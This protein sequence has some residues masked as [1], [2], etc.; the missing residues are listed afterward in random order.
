MRACRPQ[1]ILSL[2]NS[3]IVALLVSSLLQTHLQAVLTP[4]PQD[5]DELAPMFITEL[6]RAESQVTGVGDGDLVTI[7][8]F[9]WSPPINSN[10]D[11]AYSAAMYNWD[12]NEFLDGVWLYQDGTIELLAAS[13]QEAPQLDTG[14]GSNLAG[15]LG[16]EFESLN[17]SDRVQTGDDPPKAVTSFVS[18]G[19]FIRRDDEIGEVVARQ[20]WT[21]WA[22][23]PDLLN[24]VM[25]P[26]VSYGLDFPLPDDSPFVYGRPDVFLN[27]A[28]HSSAYYLFPQQDVLELIVTLDNGSSSSL[29]EVGLSPGGSPSPLEFFSNV[30]FNSGSSAFYK[31]TFEEYDNED[32]T[33]PINSGLY[34]LSNSTGGI[35]VEEGQMAPGVDDMFFNSFFHLTTGGDNFAFTADLRPQFSLPVG[36][37]TTGLWVGDLEGGL[38]LVAAYKLQDPNLKIPISGGGSIT[39]TNFQQIYLSPG[40]TVFFVGQTLERGWGIWEETSAGLL[41]LINEND[42]TVDAQGQPTAS[43]YGHLGT[44]QLY[45]N[46]EDHI[47]FIDDTDSGTGL[48]AQDP[49][50]VLRR[51]IESNQPVI[52][53]EQEVFISGVGRGES[54]SGSGGDDGRPS[55]F[56]DN[57]DLA[58]TTGNQILR[59]SFETP[60]T[61]FVW[62]FRCDELNWHSDC[63]EFNWLE[64]TPA[65]LPADHIPGDPLG[66]GP[67]E[68][69]TIPDDNVT[70]DSAPV[71]LKSIFATGRLT[72]QQPLSIS[73]DSSIEDL[74]LASDLDISS[75]LTLTGLTNTISGGEI[76]G[77]GT[78]ILGDNGN[79]LHELTFDTSGTPFSLL[80]TVRTEA[81]A[82]WIHKN[83]ELQIFEDG[84]YLNINDGLLELQSGSIRRIGL[85]PPESPQFRLAS[86]LV[87]TGSGEFNIHAQMLTEELSSMSI[88]E[89]KLIINSSSIIQGDVTIDQDASLEMTSSF[90]LGGLGSQIMSG[91]GQMIISSETVKMQPGS[92]AGMN[93]MAPGKIQ[94]E[95][96]LSIINESNENPGFLTFEKDNLLEI[97]GD[98]FVIISSQQEYKGETHIKG[99]VLELRGTSF[100]NGSVFEVDASTKLNLAEGE[101]EVDDFML[102]SGEGSVEFLIDSLFTFKIPDNP[103][104]FDLNPAQL[105]LSLPG[106]EPAGFIHNGGTLNGQAKGQ[107]L[108]RG[109]YLFK[110]G[111]LEGIEI[112]NESVSAEQAARIEFAEGSVITSSL[113][114]SIL[115]NRP[116]N[117]IHQPNDLLFE[118]APTLLINNEGDYLIGGDILQ[119]SDGF[120]EP[121]M[122]FV[123]SPGTLLANEPGPVIINES[124]AFQNQ[125]QDFLTN[126]NVELGPGAN[127]TIENC[128]NIK[129]SPPGLSISADIE[130]N[131]GNWTVNQGATLTLFNK[132]VD[133][134]V[135]A[136]I[137]GGIS[138]GST[139]ELINDGRLL[140]KSGNLQPTGFPAT[141]HIYIADQSTL[142]LRNPDSQLASSVTLR[143]GSSMELFSGTTQVPIIDVYEA[144]SLVLNDATLIVSSRLYLSN[145]TLEGNGTINGEVVSNG[146]IQPGKSPG[147]IVINGDFTQEENAVL[148]MELGGLQ[149]AG[150][151]Y[152]Q[153]VV[154]GTA[155]LNGTLM[156]EEIS[157]FDWDFGTPVDLIQATS[158]SGSFDRVV[159]INSSRVIVETSI[160]EGILTAQSNLVEN[161]DEWK[162]VNFSATDQSNEAISGHHADPDG[163]DIENLL[164]YASDTNPLQFDAMPVTFDWVPNESND[165]WSVQV[166]FPWAKG[167]TDVEYKLQTSMDMDTWEDAQNIVTQKVDGELTDQVTIEAEVGGEPVYVRLIVRETAL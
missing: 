74:R 13:G 32:G 138:G 48:W 130:I 10:G 28:G 85:L 112:I 56:S 162:T 123:N 88:E 14:S 7:S 31:G 145:G 124:V 128:L 83:G 148:H 98:E 84:G 20:S 132:E 18:Y 150:T 2:N 143:T 114:P 119:K 166:G 159:L 57:G 127:L 45:I 60:V 140:F 50:G 9:D 115:L 102:V 46:A 126:G 164:E 91:T 15:Y 81:N 55:I 1:P 64:N 154:N 72:V 141:A 35:L 52:I 165:T 147:S 97:T 78:L 133:D 8:I 146:V 40:G 5:P 95:S 93:F 129:E 65:M 53:D 54:Q 106:S 66:R 44:V 135:T 96:P 34:W 157:G 67:F 116:Q 110:L 41:E 101:H 24:R 113:L 23:E 149:M 94:L 71:S 122:E 75:N 68:S 121:S 21:Y 92:L 58:V 109:N 158:Y 103:D 38:R 27:K 117:E 19:N 120:I 49:T 17:L 47:A 62:E 163:D 144:S 61:E 51:I 104:P 139:V 6:A 22:T 87:K 30:H 59:I 86:A 107:V 99:G 77:L 39:F 12:K 134:V 4:P 70:I 37:P 131:G 111:T 79:E 137:L 29:V 108:N 69:V 142:I 33:P 151:D 73:N 76:K 152:D 11:I 89:G 80:S 90:N 155:N 26:E 3:V 42:F 16:P 125:D 105:E 156:L 160:E 161:F 136:G 82:K 43:T 25:S 153:L 118:G 36:N 100:H 167:M 63:G